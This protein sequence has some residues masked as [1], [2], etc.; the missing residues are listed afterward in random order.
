MPDISVIVACYNVANYIERAVRSALDQDGV[1]VEVIVV[2]DG[3][4][5]GTKDVLAKINDP[6]IKIITLSGNSGPSVA[7]NAGIAAATAP[8]LAVLD[9]DDAFAPGRLKACLDLAKQRK[10]DIVID[11]LTVQ[12]ENDG[13]I[14]PM[15][16][17]AMFEKLQTLTLETYIAYN[18]TFLGGGI[19][20]GY[21]KPMIATEFL[22]KR[23]LRYDPDIRVGEDYMLLADALAYGALCAVQKDAGY[24]YTMREGSISHRLSLDDVKRI[25][26]G[27]RKFKL[28]HNLGTDAVKALTKRDAA[29]Q[30]AL[31]FTQL[32]DAIK[33]RDVAA[34]LCGMIC[35]PVAALNL[36]RA[37][38]K[39]ISR[40]WKRETTADLKAQRTVLLFYKEYE[41]DKFIKGD[42]Y[43][44]RVLRPLYH[45]T[46][47][48]QKKSGFAVSFELMCRALTKAGYDV[49]IN[50]YKT[51][52]NNPDYPAGVVGFPLILDNWTLPNP[53][54]LGPSLYDHPMLRPDLFD[55]K[56]FKK[57]AVLAPW[58]LDMYKPVYGDRCFSWFAGI[59]LEQWPDL[60]QQKKK[61]DFLVY[62][63]VRW[64]H[65]KFETSLI[66]PLVETLKRRNLSYRMVRYKMYDH[67]VYKQLLNECRAIIFLCEHETQGL[68]YQE[69]MASNIPIL[70]WD[71]GFWADPL[72]KKYG[73]APPAASSV[74]FFSPACGE[75]F[76]DMPEFD[77]ALTRFLNNLS[78]YRPRQYV[79]DSLNMTKSARIYA[80][81]YFELLK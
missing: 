44:K 67:K 77:A 34:T 7:R 25:M 33:R 3:S 75:T 2:N 9:G 5:D 60:S 18:R 32:V 12:R 24:L 62:D 45:L 16:S 69:A 40:L 4:T 61:Y 8:W 36:Y 26:E 73:G 56:R 64:D 54:V 30:E 20:L 80:D 49:R 39:R 68:A 15:Y 59:D 1:S 66:A 81:Q 6:R 10:A 57:Y 27:D 41:A 63:K 13:A 70:A 71:N 51:A 38:G 43:L 58:T 14:Y 72:W 17:P 35:H 21:T 47:R 42:R 76:R 78:D 37:I 23:N 28:R 65:D 11:N 53:V 29:L 48:R 31:A 19:S 55:D 74:P 50:D 46:H 79:A 52:H 22:R